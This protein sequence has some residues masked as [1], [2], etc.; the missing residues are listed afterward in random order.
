MME[1]PG[2]PTRRLFTTARQPVNFASFQS[3]ARAGPSRRS[4]EWSNHQRVNAS[5]DFTL[6]STRASLSF[7]INYTLIC[8]I[9]YRAVAVTDHAMPLPRREGVLP[10]TV[11][12]F[13][14]SPTSSPMSLLYVSE[15][16]CSASFVWSR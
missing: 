16:C 4:R 6:Q 14:A 5:D 8:Y 7:T 10:P 11:F 9:D 3:P 13:C 1:K 2:N 12:I 15:S